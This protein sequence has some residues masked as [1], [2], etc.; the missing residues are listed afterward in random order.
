MRYRFGRREQ[1][2][3]VVDGGGVADDIAR[4]SLGR[5]PV[6]HGRSRQRYG[7][8][9][10]KHRFSSSRSLPHS[11]ASKTYQNPYFNENNQPWR[12]DGSEAGLRYLP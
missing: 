10:P 4:L 7:P 9:A 3:H 5:L 8:A 6:N 12:A 1:V 11:L 2:L